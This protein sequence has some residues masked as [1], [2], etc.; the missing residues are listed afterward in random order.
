MHSFWRLAQFKGAHTR[1]AFYHG[2]RN[3]MRIKGASH[4]M[5]NAAKQQTKQRRQPYVYDSVQHH[6]SE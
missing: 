6:N 4:N 5:E 2:K 3:I 1:Y